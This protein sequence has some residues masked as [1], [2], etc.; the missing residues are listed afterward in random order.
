MGKE[1]GTIWKP[2]RRE[3]KA[4]N[5]SESLKHNKCDVHTNDHKQYEMCRFEVQGNG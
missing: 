3:A 5:E 2:A 4:A 1:V